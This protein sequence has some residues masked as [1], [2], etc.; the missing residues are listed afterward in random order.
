MQ[1][2][3]TIALLAFAPPTVTWENSYP[4]AQQVAI[5]QNKP[6]AVVFGPGANG[7]AKL[8]RTES[9]APQVEKLLAE[10]YICVYVDT[11]TPEGQKIARN[12]D[13]TS[14]V[15]LVLSDRKGSTQAFWH[16]GDLTSDNAIHYLTKYADPN[17]VVAQTETVG[18][19]ART[20][21]YQPVTPQY[22]PQYA[23]PIRAAN[24]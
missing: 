24:C 1:S 12:F 3:L 11:S 4:A 6:L 13:I 20:S 9:S 18:S 10:H 7:W 22:A 8:L 21:Y 15:G 23:A 5:S 17:L 19:T 14:S 16:Q 2:Y